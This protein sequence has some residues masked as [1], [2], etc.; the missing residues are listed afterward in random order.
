M[1]LLQERVS[2][3]MEQGCGVPVPLIMGNSGGDQLVRVTV[4]QVSDTGEVAGS[5]GVLTPR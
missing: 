4:E 1:F 3:I 2:T 5:P